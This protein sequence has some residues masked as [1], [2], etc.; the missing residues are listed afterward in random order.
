MLAFNPPLDNLQSPGKSLRVYTGLVCLWG[1]ISVKV[2][3]A[4]WPSLQQT[5]LFPTLAGILRA[6]SKWVCL[7]AFL[8]AVACRCDVTGCVKFPPYFPGQS[9]GM[10]SWIVSWSKPFSPPKMLI[11]TTEIKPSWLLSLSHLLGVLTAMRVVIN[12]GSH[13]VVQVDLKLKTELKAIL[14]LQFFDLSDTITA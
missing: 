3:D 13:S 5:V 8:S 12:T 9:D 4:G 11:T 2:T 14:L 7:P 6:H 1:I 10:Q